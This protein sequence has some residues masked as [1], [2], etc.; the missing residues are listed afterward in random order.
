MRT[1]TEDLITGDYYLTEISD[2]GEL[3]SRKKLTPEEYNEL[4]EQRK[5]QRNNADREQA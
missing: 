3:Q 4:C 2:S 1:I 5:K